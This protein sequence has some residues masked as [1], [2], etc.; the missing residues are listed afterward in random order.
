MLCCWRCG[1]KLR[2][3]EAEYLNRKEARLPLLS[4]GSATSAMRHNSHIRQRLQ[5]L[6]LLAVLLAGL[7]L[8][9]SASPAAAAGCPTSTSQTGASPLIAHAPTLS[10]ETVRWELAQ[11]GSPLTD[12]DARFLVHAS[13]QTSIDDAFALAV[14]AAE[15]QD[16]REAVPGTHNIGN[17]TAAE[18]VAWAHHIFA[19]Y[20]TWQ[21]GIAAWFH[22]I[23]Q[24]Y[25]Q[26]GHAQNLLTFALY[27]VHGLTPAQ[28]SPQMQRAVANGYVETLSS[29]IPQLQQHEAA[30]HPGQAGAG[31]P[32]ESPPTPSATVFDL[33]P[34][35]PLPPGWAGPGTWPAASTM[36]LGGCDATISPLV[37]AGLQLGV[38]LRPNTAGIFDHWV[39]GAPAGVRSQ[40]GI[41]WDTDFLASVIERTTGVAVPGSLAA[42]FW[43]D[44]PLSQQPGWTRLPAGPKQMPQAGDIAVLLDG[45]RGEVALILGVQPPQGKQPGMVLVLQAHAGHVLERWTLQ[46]DGTL[47]PPW[48]FW[49]ATEGYL[50]LSAQPPAGTA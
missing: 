48:P 42:A 6:P 36:R 47:R 43:W 15:T 30:L 39:L 35:G 10:L 45:A 11:R 19:V 22:L 27:Y 12:A 33:L 49:T 5:A 18:G 17:I 9:I 41:T 20:P 28:A 3:L 14:W 4:E 46:P 44:E 25:V 29:I 1:E 23:K 21:A 32:D 24:L 2:W 50:R 13:Q 8:L 31:T 7:P 40:D 16:G 38:F 37:L 26:G 34:S